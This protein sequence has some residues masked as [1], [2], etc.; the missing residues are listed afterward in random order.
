MDYHV[1]ILARSGIHKPA[2]NPMSADQREPDARLVQDLDHL[3]RL[4]VHLGAPLQLADVPRDVAAN[5][6]RRTMVQQSDQFRRHRITTA[7]FPTA[8]SVQVRESHS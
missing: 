4:D 3:A 2:R 6:Q 5:S 1:N 8:Y 7:S